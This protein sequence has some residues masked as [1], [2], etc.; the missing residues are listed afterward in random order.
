VSA[1]LEVPGLAEELCEIMA[2]LSSL[3]VMVYEEP[4]R[5]SPKELKEL[6]KEL[7]AIKARLKRFI[8]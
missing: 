6:R 7:A 3:E 8:Q 5:L 4:T 1:M 2:D